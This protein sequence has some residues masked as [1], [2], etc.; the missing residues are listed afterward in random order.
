VL[1]SWDRRL[2]V[3]V[4]AAMALDRWVMAHLSDVLSDVVLPAVDR[5]VQHGRRLLGPRRR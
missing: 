5:A 4:N 3:A 2:I 1:D